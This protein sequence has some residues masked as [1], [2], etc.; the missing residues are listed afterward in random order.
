MKA[1]TFAPP[2]RGRV[3]GLPHIDE[4]G[5]QTVVEHLVEHTHLDPRPERV[6]RGA[7]DTNPSL[8]IIQ[9]AEYPKLFIRG[10]VSHVVEYEGCGIGGGGQIKRLSGP[11]SHDGA[12]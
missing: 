10:Q 5:V 4:D 9:P 6:A 1:L 12:S 3:L 8:H 7:D 11:P 2:C